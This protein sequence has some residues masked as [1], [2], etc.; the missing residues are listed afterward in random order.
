MR[1]A[2]NEY[3][4]LNAEDVNRYHLEYLRGT[5]MPAGFIWEGDIQAGFP[6][7]KYWFL[8]GKLPASTGEF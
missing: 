4:P 5:L 3:Q 8:Y 2:A 6:R 7:E 1:A